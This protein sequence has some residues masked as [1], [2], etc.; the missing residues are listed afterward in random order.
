MDNSFLESLKTAGASSA[1]VAKSFGNRFKE[2]R[3]QQA[4]QAKAERVARAADVP[5]AAEGEKS[6]ID[7]V[8]ETVRELGETV[9]S[10]ANETFESESFARARQ[11]VTAAFE[12]GREGVTE[13]ISNAKEKRATPNKAA[14]TAPQAPLDENIVEGEVVDDDNSNPFGSAS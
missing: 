12:E 13:A 14:E 9:V 2:E 7:K 8:T 5:G 11:D 6:F 10:A 1:E 3:Q 4:Q